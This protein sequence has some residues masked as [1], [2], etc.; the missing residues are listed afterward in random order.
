MC[1]GA[2]TLRGMLDIPEKIVKYVNDYKIL[3]IEARR[4]DLI[5][6]NMNN[7]DL[8]NLLEIILDKKIPKNEAKK[9]AIQYG[10]EH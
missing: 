2:T 6:H 10:W 5:L 3:L 4:N 1:R 8:F 7:V 9:K